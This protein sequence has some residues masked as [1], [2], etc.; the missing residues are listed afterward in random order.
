MSTGSRWARCGQACAARSVETRAGQDAA[1]S[2]ATVAEREAIARC[3]DYRI[4]SNGQELRILRGEFHRTRK[5]AATAR[6]TGRSKICGAMPS[7][8]PQWIGSA[9]GSRH[10]AGREYPWWLTQKT[11]DAFML[12]GSFNPMFTYER[13]VRYRR[14]IAMCLRPAW[15]PH[16]A[17]PADHRSE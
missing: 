12:P 5:S 6:M 4:S 3:R 16:P 10:G 11:T 13:S 2:P 15:H 14:G 17:S 8:W 7:M 9:A 1:A